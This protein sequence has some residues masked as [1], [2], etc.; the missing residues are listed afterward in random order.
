MKAFV[1]IFTCLF[2]V[3]LIGFMI[4]IAYTGIHIGEAIRSGN[5][6]FNFGWSVFNSSWD[7]YVISE[8][9]DDSYDNIEIGILLARADIKLSSDGITRINYSGNYNFN[10]LE[11]IA[12]IDGDTLVVKEKGFVMWGRGWSW[13]NIAGR[14]TTLD[15]ELPEEFFNKISIDITSG[16][17]NADLPETDNLYVNITSGSVTLDYNHDT[18]ANHLRSYSTSGTVRINGFSPDTYD[19]YSTSGTQRISG[20]SGSGNVRLTSGSAHVDFAEWDGALKVNVTSGSVNITVPGGSGADLRF[21]RTSG[22]V[23]YNMDGDSGS[24][25]RSGTATVGGSNKQRVEVNLTSGSTSIA[26]N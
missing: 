26:T 7:P 18:R 20:L 15:V 4:T 24:L 5:F 9:F 2:F 25:N 1:I 22:S 17:L 6:S 11:F 3:S 23:K 21:S 13:G 12:E 16:R 19:I 8:T 10:N 14:Q